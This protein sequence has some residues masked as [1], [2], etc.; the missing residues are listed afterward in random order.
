MFHMNY[1]ESEAA[2]YCKRLKQDILC[3]LSIVLIQDTKH[4]LILNKI[5]NKYS[6]KIIKPTT[7]YRLYQCLENWCFQ[8]VPSCHS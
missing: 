3:Y 5:T 4:K 2:K 7:F 1:N 8:E 6:A